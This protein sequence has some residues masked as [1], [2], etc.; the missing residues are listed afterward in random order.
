MKTIVS[1]AV[2]SVLVL[3]GALQAFGFFNIDIDAKVKS[4]LELIKKYETRID[5]LKEE[6]KYLKEK[7]AK[8]PTLYEK[9]PLYEELKDKYVYRIKLYGAS[10]D[11]INFMIKDN[12][13]SV[14][15]NMKTEQKND[16]NYFYSSQYFSSSYAIPKNVN[17]EKITHSVNGDYFEIIMPKK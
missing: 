11:Q 3:S 9:K 5:K 15:M 1:K 2:I 16:D 14:N 6:N 12:I 13:I 7:K 4:N 10:T 17:Q 8:N